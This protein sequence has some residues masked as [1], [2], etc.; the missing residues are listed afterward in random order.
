MSTAPVS[1]T[2]GPSCVYAGESARNDDL[3]QWPAVAG[4]DREHVAAKR[5]VVGDLE[6]VERRLDDLGRTPAA[7]ARE[8]IQLAE[9]LRRQHDIESARRR[10]GGGEVRKGSHGRSFHTRY[11]PGVLG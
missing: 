10:A 1:W 5:L 3:A 2:P 4:R 11:A 6:Q 8:L 9:R 7:P